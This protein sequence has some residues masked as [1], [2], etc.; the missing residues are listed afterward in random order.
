MEPAVWA[1]QLAIVTRLAAP[2][3]ICRMSAD[4]D[5]LPAARTNANAMMPIQRRR[6]AAARYMKRFY[7]DGLQQ[8]QSAKGQDGDP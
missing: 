2:F 5:F 1:K 4:D 6:H 3:A 8:G 7:D